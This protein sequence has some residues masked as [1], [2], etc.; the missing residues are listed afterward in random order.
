MKQTRTMSLIETVT[1]VVVGYVLAIATQIVVF[2]WFGIETGLAEHLGLG[3]MFVGVSLARGY[4]LRRL[5]E[6]F[7]VRSQS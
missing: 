5:F 2:P 6:A 7:R 1:N 3:L 4:L